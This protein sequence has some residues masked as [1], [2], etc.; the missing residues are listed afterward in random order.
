LRRQRRW[1]RSRKLGHGIERPVG[2]LQFF[3]NELF[4]IGIGF[5]ATGPVSLEDDARDAVDDGLGNGSRDLG[6]QNTEIFA[7]LG[8]E[9]NRS[10]PVVVNPISRVNLPVLPIMGRNAIL[11][12]LGK[13]IPY[14]KAGSCVTL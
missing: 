7:S 2:H 5:L 13:V 8:A 9:G 6:R 12:G 10:V 11:L 4:Q 1:S 3:Q 14:R